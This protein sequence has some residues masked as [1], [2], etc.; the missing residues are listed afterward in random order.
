MNRRRKRHELGRLRSDRM[1]S[2]LIEVLL[3]MSSGSV[4]L[5]LSIGL[6]HQ[7]MHWSKRVRDRGETLSQQQRLSLLW[8]QDVHA[9]QRIEQGTAEAVQFV[10]PQGQRIEY[11]A[12]QGW[13]DRTVYAAAAEPAV[14]VAGAREHYD[15][16]RIG[17]GFHIRF[18][19]LDAP[20]RVAVVFEQFSDEEQ[21]RVR[22]LAIESVLNRWAMPEGGGE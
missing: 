6:I 10:D 8:R 2:A 22:K 5:L 17:D 14:G 13:V 15:R 1:G 16:F 7:S 12:E 3:A 11:R 20:K 21:K 19:Q 9:S 4:V 18:E